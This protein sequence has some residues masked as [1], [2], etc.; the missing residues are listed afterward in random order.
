MQK[1][2][3]MWSLREFANLLCRE[4]IFTCQPSLLLVSLVNVQTPVAVSNV[5]D[6]MWCVSASWKST[7][8]SYTKCCH[9]RCCSQFRRNV[10]CFGACI[11]TVHIGCSPL[12]EFTCLMQYLVCCWVEECTGQGFTNVPRSIFTANTNT[13]DCGICSW[14]EVFHLFPEPFSAYMPPIEE[15]NRSLVIHCLVYRH[16]LP[17]L[18]QCWKQTYSPLCPTEHWAFHMYLSKRKPWHLYQFPPIHIEVGIK[19]FLEFSCKT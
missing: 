12:S 6:V 3:F 4:I 2:H 18:V 8:V 16:L 1:C 11:S 5:C 19:K 14:P 7:A 17:F 13:Y 15:H 9:C 10:S